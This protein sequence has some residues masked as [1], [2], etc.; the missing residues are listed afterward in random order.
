MKVRISALALAV[1]SAFTVASAHAAPTAVNVTANTGALTYANELIANGGTLTTSVSL[2]T[3][4]ATLGF[5][6]SAG[7][8]RYIRFDF[9]NAKIKTNAVAAADLVNSVAFDNTVVNAGG[10]VD[11]SFV[12]FQVTG[13]AV[14]GNAATETLTF[15][16]ING[17]A[18]DLAV[19]N[20]GNPVTVTYTLHETAVSAVA[21]ATGNA[22][23]V[24]KT[25]DLAK[26]APGLEVALTQG[27]PLASVEKTFKEFCDVDATCAAS[28]TEREVGKVVVGPKTGVMAPAT[29]IQVVYGDLVT[30]SDVVVTGDFAFIGTTG[31]V[32]LDNDNNATACDAATVTATLSADKKT[33]TLA[34]NA[35]VLNGGTAAAR[36]CVLTDG[37]VEIPEQTVL[38]ALDVKTKPA[39]STAADTTAA[40]VGVIGRNGTELQSPWF[41]TAAGYTSRIFL[42]NKGTTAALITGTKVLTETGNTCT[43]GT[44][45][46][47]SVPAGGMVEIPTSALCASFSASPRASAIL[48]IAA[49]SSKIQG[50]Y[51]IINPTTGAQMA[52][53][54]LRPGTN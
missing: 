29:G 40:A 7:Q 14:T 38:A 39:A 5:G 44:G 22:V 21:G 49:P 48:T 52:Y 30:T 13:T 24:T 9:G 16:F 33:A 11:D 17:T 15:S 3:M 34:A 50:V 51:Q 4:T 20:T 18:V 23:L 26:F 25:A 53:P 31:A 46:P 6:V 54:L 2:P 43:A 8:T 45:V 27:T 42:S 47:T 37:L 12:I 41:S 1:A 28:T 19:T 35:G 32:T 36:L 10:A